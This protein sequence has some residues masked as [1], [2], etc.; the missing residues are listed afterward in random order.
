MSLF[1]IPLVATEVLG[2]QGL[3]YRGFRLQGLGFRVSQ[4]FFGLK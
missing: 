1:H 2:F 4:T 3:G